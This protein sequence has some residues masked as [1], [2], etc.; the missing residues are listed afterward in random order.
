MTTLPQAAA[1]RLPRPAF[2]NL[3]G[4]HHRPVGGRNGPSPA[5]R[6][7]M[8]GADVW[9]V[10]RSNF[11]L[12]LL[13]LMVSARAGYGINYWLN[14]YHPRYTAVGKVLVLGTV[15][16]TAEGLLRESNSLDINT[17]RWKSACIPAC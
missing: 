15:E 5:I 13:M 8:T 7:D 3:A 11:W 2:T 4:H 12:I 10:I 6:L 16:D 9:R 17:C 14:K 1:L